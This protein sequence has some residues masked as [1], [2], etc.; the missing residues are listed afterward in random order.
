[1]FETIVIGFIITILLFGCY[2]NSHSRTR[3]YR[4]SIWHYMMATTEIPE[5]PTEVLTEQVDTSVPPQSDIET[6]E[7]MA[8]T[9]SAADNKDREMECDNIPNSPGA[10]M[11]PATEPQ[12][13]IETETE[14][15][16]NQENKENIVDMES[17]NTIPENVKNTDE[18]NDSEISTVISKPIESPSETETDPLPV[19]VLVPV[20]DGKETESTEKDPDDDEGKWTK[21]KKSNK[22]V[23]KGVNKESGAQKG[24][25][26]Y[27]TDSSPDRELRS[28]KKKMQKIWEDFVNSLSKELQKLMGGYW[29]TEDTERYVKQE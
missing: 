17:E 15:H 14:L 5:N 28:T 29:A 1:M 23:T 10:K 7:N 22:K 19:P 13:E 8:P 26:K 3:N 11:S 4:I 16:K 12:K 2:V 6:N 9:E 18:T 24:A 25:S 20:P 21:V 27:S